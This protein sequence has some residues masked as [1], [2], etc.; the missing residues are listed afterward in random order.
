MSR[1]EL[2]N[3][4]AVLMMSALADY[5]NHARHQ[6]EWEDDPRDKTYW[7]A[8]AERAEVLSEQI[9]STVS[10]ELAE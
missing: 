4:D 2:D 9:A 7:D 8:Q 3:G 1:F 5:A 6:V 10:L